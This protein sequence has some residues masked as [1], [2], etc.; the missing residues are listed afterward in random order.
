[1]GMFDYVHFQ[2]PCPKCGFLLDRFQ[3]KDA[4]C[5]LRTI[6][7]EGLSYFYAMCKCNRWVSFHRPQPDRP[8]LRGTPLTREQIEAMGFVLEVEEPAPIAP[9]TT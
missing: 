3:T 8:P 6:E 9:A 7:P 4:M 2:M 5:E 1:M